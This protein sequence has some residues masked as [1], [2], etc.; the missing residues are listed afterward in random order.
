MR[1]YWENNEKIRR[2][3]N[4]ITYAILLNQNFG[5]TKPNYYP[6]NLNRIPA[7]CDTTHPGLNNAIKHEQ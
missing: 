1:K 3:E 4:N 5:S 6:K 7:L 2:R